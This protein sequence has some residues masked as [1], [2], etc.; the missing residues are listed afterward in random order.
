MQQ[1]YEQTMPPPAIPVGMVPGSSS[2]VQ[3][4]GLEGPAMTD[5]AADVE[6]GPKTETPATAMEGA[7]AEAAA[8]HPPD[9]LLEARTADAEFR[10]TAASTEDAEAG[11]TAPAIAAELLVHPVCKLF[12]M[13]SDDDLANLTEDIRANGQVEK[14][15][16]Y[17]G[18]IVDGRNRL[19]ACQTLGVE[20]SFIQWR[21][22]YQGQMDVAQ[23]IFSMNAKR[24]HLT[25]KQLAAAYLALEGWRDLERAQAAKAEGQ[26]RGGETAGRG[27]P[28]ADSLLAISPGSNPAN[29]ALAAL[30]TQGDAPADTTAEPKQGHSTGRR[31]KLAIEFG[32]SDHT[33]KQL[34]AV[35]KDKPELLTEIAQ[36]NINPRE[37]ANRARAETSGKVMLKPK[38]QKGTVLTPASELDRELEKWISKAIRA[39]EKVLAEVPQE[40]QGAFTSAVAETVLNLA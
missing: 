12:P 15:V 8:A 39:V 38:K 21:E 40:K 5:C 20:P 24:R 13:M 34:L 25:P 3:E 6:P 1:Q 22:R 10:G 37:A 23:W 17:E 26:K 27:R 29:A 28:K 35:E 11:T 16:M 36:G 14:I 19:K 2:G 32:V 31:K 4:Q 18:Q 9:A 33:A 30:P 7:T